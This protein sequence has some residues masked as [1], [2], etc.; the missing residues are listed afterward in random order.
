MPRELQD[1]HVE[2]LI[3]G[4]GQAGLSMSYL[5]QQQGLSHLILEKNTLGHAWRRSVGTASA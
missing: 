2:V 5:L 4:G 1:K 3:I